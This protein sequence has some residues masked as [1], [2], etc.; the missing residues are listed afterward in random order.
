[1]IK[2]SNYRKPT[3]KERRLNDA[4]IIAIQKTDIEEREF[5]AK[6]IEQGTTIVWPRMTRR[7]IEPLALLVASLVDAESRLVMREERLIHGSLLGV[8]K[9]V[10]SFRPQFF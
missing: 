8:A 4:I 10:K 7:G 5:V 1:M 3:R 2:G 9:F 6:E